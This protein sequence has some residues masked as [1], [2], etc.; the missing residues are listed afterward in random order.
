[1]VLLLSA[2]FGTSVQTRAGTHCPTAAVQMVRETV[3]VR[4]CCG[5]LVPKVIERA[6]LAGE[7]EFLQCQCA[8][9]K[10][11]AQREGAQYQSCPEALVPADALLE[12]PVAPI[13]PV[14]PGSKL[15]SLPEVGR[16]PL[17][18]PPTS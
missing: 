11:S 7:A 6:P 12:F 3:L 5:K 10:D 13:L 1:M 16:V 8:E 14:E 15:E 18:P 2:C 4:N 9:K 17:V